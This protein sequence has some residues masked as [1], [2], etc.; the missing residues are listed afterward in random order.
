MK[1]SSV[2]LQQ[3]VGNMFR[4]HWKVQG[5][6]R[7]LDHGSL[8]ELQKR[9]MEFED[10]LDVIKKNN[11]KEFIPLKSFKPVPLVADET[12]PDY[13]EEPCLTYKDHN[14]LLE[15]FT[16][17]K[18]LTNTVEI[19]SDVLPLQ[20]DISL[21]Q[22]LPLQDKLVKRCIKSSLL[23]DSMQE[24]L[25]KRHDPSREAW[26]FPREYGITDKRRNYLLVNRLLQLCSSFSPQLLGQRSIINSAKF[27]VP[28]TLPSKQKI[29]FSVTGDAVV[30][31]DKHPSIEGS[32]QEI[33]F[34]L[35]DISPLS[36]VVS[37]EESN[38][39]KFEQ[40]FPLTSD[41]K[42]K[43]IHT[44]VV[45]YNETQVAN[46]FETPVT[47]DQILGRSLMQAWIFAMSQALQGSGGKLKEPITVQTVHTNGQFFHFSVLQLNSTSCASNTE[48]KNYFWS[49]PVMDIVKNCSYEK[50]LPVFEDY[51]PRVF[52]TLLAFYNNC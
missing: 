16:Q 9:G 42:L 27:V 36:P 31:A 14:V 25:P 37:L 41:A 43:K 19:S 46:L 30:F 32:Q 47:S 5:K 52:K 34:E 49:F 8:K 48:P 21:E 4:E 44:A 40:S 23:Y 18:V 39:F 17:A 24:K 11:K 51:N 33:N 10:A 2:R 20:Q 3:H 45:H 26:I 29:L 28:V 22:E 1:L 38:I 35:P 15:G 7:V 12:H 50:G 13:H 6:K